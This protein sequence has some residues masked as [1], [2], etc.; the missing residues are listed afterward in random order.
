[1]KLASC[2][3]GCNMKKKAKQKALEVASKHDVELLRAEMNGVKTDL[4]VVKNDIRWM[5]WIMGG[6]LGAFGLFAVFVL[7]LDSNTNTHM[8]AMEAR[9]MQAIR[10]ASIAA[11]VGK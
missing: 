7:H 1:M 11:E 2:A 9:L 5:K 3:G 4:Q 8:Q 10:S 6:M